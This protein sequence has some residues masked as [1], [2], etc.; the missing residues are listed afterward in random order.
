MMS[1]WIKSVAV[2]MDRQES[3]CLKVLRQKDSTGFKAR[4]H[5]VDC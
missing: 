4:G 2:P 3:P 5:F 1:K